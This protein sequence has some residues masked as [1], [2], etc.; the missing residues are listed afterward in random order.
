VLRVPR[1]GLTFASERW[2]GGERLDRRALSHVS[3]SG[4]GG[5]M[6]ICDPHNEAA[7]QRRSIRNAP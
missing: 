2:T 4:G 3:R 1:G 5:S 6:K 7:P